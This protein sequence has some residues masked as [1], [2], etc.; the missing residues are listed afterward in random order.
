MN[1]EDIPTPITDSKQ[2]FNCGDVVDAT[3]A[4]DLERKLSVA[5]AALEKAA[6]LASIA[7]DWDLGTDGR[8]EI[9][10]QWISCAQLNT[11]FQETLNQLNA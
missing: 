6:E 4:R 3:D 7:Y 10:G 5:R 1:L 9:D 8:V 2:Y 11:E